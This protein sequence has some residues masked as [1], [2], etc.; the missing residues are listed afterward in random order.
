MHTD[1]HVN[2][3]S[4]LVL[5]LNYLGHTWQKLL[6]IEHENFLSYF[7]RVLEFFLEQLILLD[8]AIIGPL[9]T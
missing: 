7:C 6:V 1:L 5:N 9:C 3:V 4:E 8:T 2:T